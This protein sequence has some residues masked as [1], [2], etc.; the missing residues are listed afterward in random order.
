MVIGITGA[1]GFIG[2]ALS[3]AATE[4]GHEVVAFSRQ[5]SATAP[6]VKESRVIHMEEG[7][8]T[9]DPTGLDALVH[10]AGESVMSYWTPAKKRR[11]RESR[12]DLTRRIVQSLQ[13][14][15]TR[16]KAFICASASGAYGHRG[17][18][19]LTEA[20]PRGQGFLAEV[21]AQWEAAAVSAPVCVR[22]LW[23][24]RRRYQCAEIRRFLARG[25]RCAS[26]RWRW[27]G[28]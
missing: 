13:K 28:G 25:I 27:R 19:W 9:L 1:T 3:K 10:L 26:G 4:R 17:D 20:S 21:C 15:A 14:C 18:E 12:V 24:D 16:P 7:S 23:T 8:D 6:W 22:A 11:I 2:T 5:P